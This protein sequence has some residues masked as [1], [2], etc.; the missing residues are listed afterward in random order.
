MPMSATT[1]TLTFDPSLPIS[2]AV[3]EI[4]AALAAHQVIVVAGETGSGKTTQLP[5][6][7]LAAG[8]TR[9]AHTQPRRIAARSVAT[10]IAHEMGVDLG[11][12]VGYQVRFTRQVGRQTALTLMTDGILLAQIAHDRD[13][14]GYDT[15]IID[16]AHERSLN[17]DFLLGY[18]KQLLP[19]RPDL[20]VIITSATIDTARFSAHFDDAPVI[21]VSGRTFPVELL[22]EPLAGPD[23]LVEGIARAVTQLHALGDG[24]ILVF[25]SGE[26]DIRDAADA[27]TALKLPHTE[28]LPLYARLSAAE[29]DKVFTQH[30]GMR[31]VLA[32]NVAETSLTV[33]GIRSVVDPGL[34]RIS[35]Y[36][37]RTK[38]QRLPIEEI[39]QASANQRAGR[40]GRIG[41]GIA[42]RLYSEDDFAARPEFTEPEILR[43]NLASVILQ[44]ADA[45]LGPIEEFPFV[46]PPDRSQVRDGLRL[47]RELGAL[48]ESDTHGS[49]GQR[50]T[51]TGRL[52]ARLPVDPRLGR[53]LV[54][55]SRRDVS[56]V[57]VPIVAALAIPDVRERPTEHQA[58]ADA[59]HRRFWLPVDTEGKERDASDL[60]ATWRLWRYLRGQQKELSGNAFRRMC[61]DEY[62]H[63]LRFREWQD[64]TTQLRDISKELHLGRGDG[65][66]RG[67]AVG[68]GSEPDWDAVHTAALAGLLSH[69]G[70]KE[71]AREPA[72]PAR[73]GRR[74]LAEY[75]A[76][77]GARYAIQPGSAA[78]KAEPPLVTTVELVETSRLWA[79]TVAPIS[80]DM[81]EEVGAHLLVHQ[82]G[83]PHWSASRGQAVAEERVLLLGVPIVAGR[84]IGY[85]RVDPVVAREIFLRS[86]L[87]EGD[88][89]TRH[90]FFARNQ[91][92][93]AE[94]EELEERTR[95]R[96]IAA[97]DDAIYAFY[98][99]RVPS[100]ITSVAAFDRWWRD[101]RREDDRFLDFRVD[102]LI[103]D[104]SS[105]D[106]SEFPDSWSVGPAEL[107]VTYAFDPG[108][109]RDGV[110]VEVDVSVLNQ[111]EDAPFTWQV[112]GL[113][114]ELATELI[115]AL[116]KSVRIRFVPAPD[117]ARRALV[118]LEGRAEWDQRPFPDAFAA[119]LG[120][121]SGEPVP[122]SL[123]SLAALP[124][125][126]RV[127]YVITDG[128]RTLAE[129]KDY[130]SLRRAHA[131][132][133]SRHLNADAAGLAH[134]GATT[135]VFGRLP[136]T[137]EVARRG[138]PLV[139]YPALVDEGDKVGV[140]V[141]NTVEQATRWQA[142]GLRRLIAVDSPDPTRSVFSRL[143]NTD[144][145]ALS[146]G[147]YASVQA[148]LAD[149]RLRAIAD[150][151]AAHRIDPDAVR[152]PAAY[153]AAK[154][155]VRPDVA[156]RM[157][158]VTK[159]AASILAR[160]SAIR[161]AVGNQAGPSA[162]D[163]R[164]QLDNLVFPGFVAAT[165]E[166]HFTRIDRYLHALQVRV[167]GWQSHPARERQHMDTISALEE[168]YDAAIAH[169]P[170]GELP[171]DAVEVGW[172]LEELRVSLFAQ[173]LGTAQSVSAKR[174][175][176][177]I[178]ALSRSGSG[179][180]GG[181]G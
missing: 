82:Y 120:A 157:Q 131:P 7:A 6:I 114:A 64:L 63:F 115:R 102:D 32:T 144:K 91:R 159:L 154:D 117:W 167:D 13:L 111:V 164:A 78:A 176:A 54:E 153:V 145:I 29:Q 148:L 140:K 9:I 75:R 83:E 94:A 175:R 118:W 92:A 1:P 51:T 37:A 41:P 19:R 34:A 116:P 132:Q 171:A 61:R 174:V 121:L 3:E 152:D 49:S 119:A 104:L 53:M 151:L 170:V 38:V 103:E 123:F 137:A 112:P 23:D 124:E 71:T 162:A 125:H 85:S 122:A 113:R 138:T 149:A 8:R 156:D 67:H 129:G 126:L 87:V 93:R 22:Y 141:A 88:W 161:A 68:T 50:L 146:S 177:A 36:S 133:L 58:E 181:H 26:R 106:V 21:E 142:L 72:A 27:I 33:P 101:K 105:L 14:R 31:V 173:S 52:L 11:G 169:Y 77:R 30:S 80:A 18:L 44:M 158:A 84:T 89:R 79:R 163:A 178:A 5:K 99:R 172:L 95:R 130:D 86:A 24:D 179:Y 62:L 74:P 59:S 70:L 160:A 110:S 10:R 127:R 147:P 139:G 15:I 16:E 45:K 100:S 48:E 12:V 66:R 42:I 55:A 25:C 39:S 180:S 155:A 46:E 109:G 81:V 107:P 108:A 135:W 65:P 98:D 20:K 150:Q 90:H 143:S 60:A 168:G 28:V 166:P 165:P 47:L 96:D 136:A 2:G 69:V 56:D 57:M 17:I 4:S 97:D 40:C 128:P 35:R 43:T 76:A 73:R 134:A